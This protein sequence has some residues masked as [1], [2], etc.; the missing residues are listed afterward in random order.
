MCSLEV[1]ESCSSSGAIANRSRRRYVGIMD[2]RREQYELMDYERVIEAV[3]DWSVNEPNVRS[4][5]LTGSGADAS[6]HPLSDRDIELYVR[7]TLPLEQDDDWWVRL[8]T[9]LAVERLENGK[10]QPTRLIYYV[11]GKLDFTLIKVGGQ[12]EFDRP[13]SVLLDKDD[14]ARHFVRVERK[15]A[16]PDQELFDECTNWAAS[17]ALMA[18]KAIV[19]D[20]PWSVFVRDEGFKSELLRMIEWDHNLRYGRSR[21]VRYLGTRMRQWMDEETQARLTRCWMSFGGDNSDAL[22]KTL[23]LFQALATRVATQSDLVDF[24]HDAVRVEV[25][26]ILGVEVGYR[27]PPMPRALKKMQ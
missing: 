20:E 17:A 25:D 23:D 1:G 7:D 12:S 18:A 2:V 27:D 3:V 6:A 26:R 16:L 13:F 21:D 10:G 15:L 11:G 5:V 9:V 8:G 24:H 4:V 19:R 22:R 14:V